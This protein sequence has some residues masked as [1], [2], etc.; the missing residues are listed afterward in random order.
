MSIASKW[1]SLGTW[2]LP[3]VLIAGCGSHG[4]S[5]T[6]LVSGKVSYRNRA[7]NAGTIV[8]TPDPTRGAAGDPVWA[9]IGPDGSYH[10]KGGATPGLAP[11][12]YRVTVAAVEPGQPALGQRFAMPRSLLPD[13]YRDPELSGL[14]CEVRQGREN[15]INFN[16]E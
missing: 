10:L 6:A 12:W 15:S 11:G 5:G 13:K 16:L 14:A 8:F 7:L 1:Q 3:L 4:K 9:D 2:A